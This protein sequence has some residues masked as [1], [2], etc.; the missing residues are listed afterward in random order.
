MEYIE[1]RD[2]AAVVRADGPLPLPAALDYLLQT[3]RGLAFAHA[4]GVVHRDIKPANLLVGRQG[5]VKILDLGLA[6]LEDRRAGIS[7]CRLVYSD[8]GSSVFWEETARRYGNS[9]CSGR[10]AT[11]HCRGYTGLARRSDFDGR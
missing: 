11:V 1:G 5:L 10:A 2:L 8:Y 6:R 7:L 4:H 3:A 9:T